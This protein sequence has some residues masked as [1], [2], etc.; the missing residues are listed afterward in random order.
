MNISKFH[1]TFPTEEKFS[2]QLNLSILKHMIN[3]EF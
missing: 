1:H 2:S 3:P